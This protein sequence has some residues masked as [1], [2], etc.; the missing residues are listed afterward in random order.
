[1]SD[2]KEPCRAMECE[3]G[4]HGTWCVEATRADI[5]ERVKD[6][7]RDLMWAF[8]L[9]FWLNGSSPHDDPATPEQEEQVNQLRWDLN[10]IMSLIILSKRPMVPT[11]VNC[12]VV[13]WTLDTD[14]RV[15]PRF[16]CCAPPGSRCRFGGEHCSVEAYLSEDDDPMAYYAPRGRANRKPLDGNIDV[17]L[18]PLGEGWLWDYTPQQGNGWAS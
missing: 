12:H 7:S 14:G 2:T 5:I 3:R 4:G 6:A 9:E 13:A 17:W 16:K 18:N 10:D 11:H 15:T 8:G 1:M